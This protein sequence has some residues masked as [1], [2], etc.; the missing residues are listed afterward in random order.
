MIERMLICTDLDRTLLPNGSQME[1]PGA[2]ERFAVLAALPETTLAYV[3]GRHR[4]LVEEAITGYQLPFPDFLIADVGT[5]I[6]EFSG[7]DWHRWAEWDREIAPDWKGK[8][9]EDLTLLFRDLSDLKLQEREKQGRFKL[10]YYVALSADRISMFDKMRV[11]LEAN[12]VQANLI[13]SV[14]EPVG[15]GLLDVLPAGATKFHAVE[16]L[17]G[18]LEFKLED[19][20]FAGD[21]GND[22]AVLTSRI[23]S[24]LVANAS[25]EVKA[26]A[27]QMADRLGTSASLYFAQGNFMGMNGNYSAGILEGVCH[28]LP[29]IR[30]WIEI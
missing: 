29:K 12:D 27:R 8:A 1:S 14:D 7:Q 5:T 23:Q 21:S 30:K 17:M 28:F 4:A 25:P 24:V 26:E 22:L 15:M 20:V 16:F 18:Q 3:T 19:T 2:R 6:Y 11:R 10:S 13:W 9:V